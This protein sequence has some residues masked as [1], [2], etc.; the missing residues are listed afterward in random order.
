MTKTRG[1]GR[2]GEQP[3]PPVTRH[4]SATRSP[5]RLAQI[6]LIPLLLLL[7]SCTLFNPYIRSSQLDGDPAAKQAAGTDQKTIY[8]GGAGDAIAAA[9]DQRR[10]YF[11]ASGHQ[12]MFNSLAGVTLIGLSADAIY[13]GVAA[14]SETKQLA[15][16]T[17]AGALAYGADVWLHNKPAEA[18]YIVG[19]QAITCTLLRSRAILLKG[20][21]FDEF[22]SDIGTFESDIGAVD[23]Q[24]SNLQLEWDLGDEA[25]DVT[26]TEALD[27]KREIGNV[28]RALA[29]SRKLLLRAKAYES[30]VSAAGE[31]IRKQVDLIVASVSGQFAPS[32][33][34]ISALN[35]VLNV[36]GD[37]SKGVA[38]LQAVT[39]SPTGTAVTPPSYDS[40]DESSSS[41]NK[42][43][44]AAGALAALP[45]PSALLNTPGYQL[46]TQLRQD[47]W[48]LVSKL[49]ADGRRLNSVLSS[50]QNFYQSTRQISS[51]APPGGLP[52]LQIEPA[53]LQDPVPPGTVLKFYIGGGL[54]IPEVTLIGVTGAS[55]DGKTQDL[56]LGVNGTSLVA[57][58]TVLPGASGTLTL[59]AKDKGPP[60]QQAKVAIDVEGE[61]SAAGKPT[62][63]ATP[64]DGS[65]ELAF[66]TPT[67]KGGTLSGYTLTLTPS[68]AAKPVTLQFAK[69]AQ[70]TAS[71]GDS[72]ISGTISIVSGSGTTIDISGLKNGQ[73]YTVGLTGSFDGASAVVFQTVDVTPTATKPQ[74][75]SQP[76]VS[77][78]DK[79][80][81]LIFQT[82]TPTNGT[83]SGYTV[84]LT[85]GDH[86][87]FSLQITGITKDS[88]A[89]APAPNAGVTATIT[90]VTGGVTTVT[91]AGLLND[92]TYTITLTANVTGG[93][94]DQPIITAVKVTP[95]A[96]SPAAKPAANVPAG[97]PPV[98]AT[99]QAPAA[100]A[101]PATPSPPAVVP[102]AN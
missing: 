55:A 6:T 85:P 83:L 67:A 28:I 23:K 56:S 9:E 81:Q 72:K 38:D 57:T 99:P 101:A 14:K 80:A 60:A 39:L 75:S 32:E 49:Y 86:T 98:S 10:L 35:K 5:D 97:K 36:F 19:F 41:G 2:D 45:A 90:K 87:S 27:L 42:K 50:A 26:A 88:S 44:S 66:S 74:D 61:P 95:T 46:R 30:E 64:G 58:V 20:S 59:L 70:G 47:L 102:A 68:G 34:D 16:L 92:T 91:V 29:K 3:R 12:Y 31:T 4:V 71:T 96:K 18:A 8:A 7:S 73:S 24:L 1:V 37:P 48:P 52:Q 89:T 84:A 65:V 11:S 62:L 69:P 13:K 76:K 100:P 77:A 15:A 93:G 22:Q 63:K 51:C 78:G 53:S 40:R 25:K 33:P 82:P 43:S 21:E 94:S 79:N 54:G 17:A